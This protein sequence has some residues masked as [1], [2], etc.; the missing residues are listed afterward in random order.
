MKS[1]LTITLCI[2]STCGFS[3]DWSKNYTSF[4]GSIGSQKSFYTEVG[5]SKFKYILYGYFPVSKSYYLSAEFSPTLRPESEN[6][7]YALKTGYEYSVFILS[8]AIDAKYQTDF[9]KNDFVITP[10]IGLGAFGIFTLYYG[11]NIS[12]QNK[13][14]DRIGTHQLSLVCNLNK[15]VL[16][17][18]LF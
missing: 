4:H 16:K 9:I 13:P 14:F 18:C 10:K 11:Y 5:V 2:I 15:H 6:H 7:I 12:I 17:D 3:Q 8:L 1:I